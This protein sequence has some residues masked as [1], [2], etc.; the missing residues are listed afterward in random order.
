MTE[1]A[2][3]RP[4][5]CRAHAPRRQ[6]LIVAAAIL[7]GQ[8]VLFG[9]SLVGQ[10]ILLP[11]DILGQ[12]NHY[13]PH[14]PLLTHTQPE[15]FVL[16]DQVLH[17]EPNRLFAAREIGQ[18]R[19]PLWNPHQ[20]A[21]APH[22]L[23]RFSPFMLLRVLVP[24]PL[25]LPWV[26]V[27]VALLAGLGAY[28]FCRT[29]LR[30]GFWPSAVAGCCFPISAYFVFWQGYGHTWSLAWLP[31]LLLAEER[32]IRRTHRAAG[33][34]VAL[35]TCLVLISGPLDTGM[36]ELGVAGLF[37]LW[38]FFSEY[39]KA[40]RS[41]S[42]L[43]AALF[44][45]LGWTAGLL[46][47]APEVLSMAAYAKTGDR[48]LRR[49][50]GAIERS[51]PGIAA[52][53]LLVLP[54]F[55]GTPEHHGVSIAGPGQRNPM[56]SVSMG[57]AGVLAV[58]LL[59]PLA[60]QAR[61]HRKGAI[62]FAGLAVLGL[63]YSVNLPG[64]TALLRLPG[65]NMMSHNRLLFATSLAVTALAALGLEAIEQGD[66]RWRPWQW[67]PAIL[68]AGLAAL[69]GL[70][71][72]FSPA[73]LEARFEAAI[74]A[75]ST[76]GWMRDA[77]AV[78]QA[79][80]SW[81]QAGLVAACLCGIA[82]GAWLLLRLKG[83]LSRRMARWLGVLMVVDLLYFGHGWNVQSDPALYYPRL[84]V[85]EEIARI[86]RGRVLGF[87]CLPAVLPQL[88]GLGDVRGYDAVDPQRL[89][90]LLAQVAAPS[91]RPLPYAALQW[92]TP[93]LALEPPATVRLPP[94][95]DMLN[96]RTVIFRG[97]PPSGITPTF[98]GEDYW[99]LSNPRALPR[100]F[101]PRTVQYVP[102]ARERL[103]K[104]SASD[105]DA[106]DVAYVEEPVAL[107]GD[108]NGQ[109][110]ITSE[111]PTHVTL[112]A[113]MDTA[114][115]VVLSDSFDSGWRAFRGADEIPIL[116]VNHAVRGMIVPA[117]DSRIDLHYWPSGF[118]WG[119]GLAG[120]ALLL[121]LAWSAAIACTRLRCSS[122]T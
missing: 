108:A 72:S 69:A 76:V 120:L 79:K 20:F 38:T 50:Q 43:R 17:A 5:G 53:P 86:D 89:V 44:V 2:V 57:Y 13:L 88:Y 4:A 28:A 103:Q 16:S 29:T 21:G 51:S 85:L 119:L 31:W 9:P 45:V 84:P 68:A 6:L 92:Y 71:A 15:N 39:G 99:A 48:M 97:R 46:L 106:R 59:A 61:R 11:L 8:A 121:L 41:R 73:S 96:V 78:A 26:Q 111:I 35:L 1:G 27:L 19:F 24:S 66:V 117:G 91:W 14:T 112:Q 40:W 32:A 114:G 23:M 65:L 98:A 104:L 10:K 12:A 67:A 64:L 22:V 42:A 109:V 63:G 77:V 74:Q 49:G 100:A 101:V 18:G 37:A 95:L 70:R 56:E 107:P 94:I 113:H 25:V 58:L 62:F 87:D 116:R 110:S 30:L 47:T 81:Q 34:A 122:L 82:L 36:Q 54:N 90:S 75:S 102:S 7:L 60:W 80:R 105:F 3:A 55:N 33:P 52:L 115:L 83:A 93:H 118:T